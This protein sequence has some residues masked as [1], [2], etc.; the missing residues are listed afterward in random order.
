MVER[1]LG[2]N[3]SHSWKVGLCSFFRRCYAPMQLLL[4]NELATSLHHSSQCLEKEEEENG[5]KEKNKKQKKIFEI[6][7]V[8]KACKR[9][10]GWSSR[11]QAGRPVCMGRR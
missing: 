9:L 7:A 10:S 3:F 1:S 4:H 6:P 2:P 8:E 11:R 5:R